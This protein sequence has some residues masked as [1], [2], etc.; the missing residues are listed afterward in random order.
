MTVDLIPQVF[1]EHLLGARHYARPRVTE[2]SKTTLGIRKL[3]SQLSHALPPS[4]HLHPIPFLLM[5]NRIYMNHFF[6]VTE[7]TSFET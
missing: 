3:P 2:M 6:F 7:H 4:L 1:A 5:L